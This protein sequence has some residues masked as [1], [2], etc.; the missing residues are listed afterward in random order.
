MTDNGWSEAVIRLYADRVLA[1]QQLFAHRHTSATPPFHLE[2]IR[3]FHG[4]ERQVCDIAF[5]GSAKSTIAEEAMVI[6]ASFREFQ[7]GFIVGASLPKAMERLH[8]IRRQFENNDD[9]R[10]LFDD[11][12]GQPW[13]DE[14]I[15]LRSGVTIQA[16]G[17]GQAIRGTKDEDI[18]PDFMLVDD[19]EDDESV[20]TPEGREKLQGWFFADL[21]PAGDA[22]RLR[23]RVLSNDRHPECLANMLKRPGSGFKVKVYP[24]EYRDAAGERRATWPGRYP[25]DYI[26]GEQRK[27]YALGK[28]AEYQKEYMCHSESPEDKPFKREMFR[29]EPRVRVWQPVY[30]AF[31]PAR[32]VRTT[33]AQTGF[34]CWSWIANR[35]VLW[36]AWG[37]R[38]LPDEIITSIF[39]VDA[40]YHPISIG[41]D[42][43]GLNEFIAQP[44][45][46]QAIARG[47][48]LPMKPL[49]LRQGKTERVRGLQPFFAA[50]E[51]EFAKPLPELEAQLLGFPT[52]LVDILDAL[53][54]ALVMRPGAPV[55]EDF[56]TANV[57]EDLALAPGQPCWLVL[58]AT[59]TMLA[60]QLVQLVQGGVRIYRDW[61]REG[62]PGDLLKDLVAE[63]NLEAARSV[64]A[65]AGPLHFNHYNNVGLRQSAARLALDIRQGTAPELG[66]TEVR[67]ML[68]RQSRGMP[69]LLVSS[70]ARWTLN[71]FAGGYARALLKGG[72]LADFAEEG[73]YRVL[74]EGLE[75]FT[76][77]LRA[78]SPDADDDTINYEYTSDGRRY[79]SARVKR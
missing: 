46:H 56:S 70:E 79:I 42:V 21:L 71:A 45:R 55:Y 67:A 48:V 64:R 23:V 12:R 25:L 31:D 68:R 51:V 63:A 27:F 13:T 24:W 16:V 34:A 66:R 10:L 29:V 32:T 20:R 35:L 1:H 75:S 9:L 60:G 77:L 30:A 58:N 17:R 39:A 61:I 37:K 62:D 38:L 2:I 76:G 6:M 11:Q 14:K 78:G 5:R 22:P 19:I 28:A 59:R 47:R 36:D 41:M 73:V 26:D 18:R 3:D 15:E 50:R 33:S 43:T 69:A 54:N 44:L 53:A 65:V 7:H 49:V 72:Q 57:M 52:G 4:V 8:S 40:E 74:M